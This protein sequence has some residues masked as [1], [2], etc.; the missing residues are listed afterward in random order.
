MLE[1]LSGL[2]PEVLNEPLV[3]LQNIERVVEGLFDYLVVHLSLRV[4]R[5]DFYCVG[6]LDFVYLVPLALEESMRAE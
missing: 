3:V 5:V 6:V 4:G 1:L 2:D